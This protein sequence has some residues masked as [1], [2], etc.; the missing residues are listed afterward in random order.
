ML[1]MSG[2]IGTSCRLTDHVERLR[3][4]NKKNGLSIIDY[5]HNELACHRINIIL[6][7][8]RTVIIQS[9]FC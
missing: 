2:W 3:I 8:S 7:R 6:R 4:G 5:L 9:A 1:I